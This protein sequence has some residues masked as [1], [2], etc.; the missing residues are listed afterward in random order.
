[1]S[2]SLPKTDLLLL[3][4]LFLCELSIT[5]MPMAIYMK[6]DRPF[7][8]FYSSKPGAVFLVAIAVLLIA[9]AVITHQYLTSTRS[10]SNHFSLIVRMNL[11]TVTLVLITAEIAIRTISRSSKEGE[12]LGSMVLLPK[13]WE[14]LALF[15]REVLDRAPSDLSFH[16]YDD[17]MGWTIGPNRRSADGLY[18]SS[19]EGIRAPHAGVTFSSFSGKT[20][21]ALMGDSYTFGQ[22][23]MYED[24][25]GHLL[26]EALG[27]EIQ[28]L[29]FGVGG[30]GIDQA[31]LRY[32][33]DARVWK[34]KIVIFGF[35]SHDATRT[36]MVYPFLSLPHWNTPF[37][38]P[39]FILRD[40]DLKLLNVP[41]VAP[42]AIFWKASISELPFLEYDPDYKQ[43]DW[44]KRLYHLSYLARVFVSE[45]PRWSAVSPDHSDEALVSVNAAILK[46]FVRSAAQSGAIPIVVYFPHETEF[47]KPSTSLPVGKRVLHEAGIAYIET[48]PCLLKLK[49]T[50]RFVPSG[51][52]YSPQGNAAV[53]NCLRTVVN[54]ALAAPGARQQSNPRGAAS[55][56]R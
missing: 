19:S 5:V 2:P 6:G 33:K 12:S 52:H 24:T 37:S 56:P 20:R 25:W 1:M 48:T 7:Q 35:I 42:E 53:A 54:A 38:T 36:M 4:S 44:E 50:D 15:Y 21:V 23:V 43:S 39:R 3:A 17:L 27:S 26:E 32:E 34:P 9:G 47:S 46:A 40:G 8:V 14:K 41:P 51:Q 13:N 28:V 31:Y 49:P 16:V 11:L 30:Y 55:V 29:N 10:P 18:W 22:E 45:F